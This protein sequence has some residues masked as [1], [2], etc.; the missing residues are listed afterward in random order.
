MIYFLCGSLICLYLFNSQDENGEIYYFNFSSGDSVWD[1]PC[2]EYFKDMVEEERAKGKPIKATKSK[3]TNVKKDKKKDK[4]EKKD[5]KTSG[6]K[7]KV[8]TIYELSS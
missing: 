5:K 7:V 3:N 1:H 4:K 6:E 2:D 8:R